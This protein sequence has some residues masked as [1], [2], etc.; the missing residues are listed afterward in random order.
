M[1]AFRWTVPTA[2]RAPVRFLD[3]DDVLCLRSPYGGFDAIAAV[4][5]LHFDAARVYLELFDP[6][7]TEAL[8]RV[9]DE[10]GAAMR[11]VISSTWR[12]SFSRVQLEIVFRHAGLAFV[13]DHLQEGEGWRTPPKFGRSRRIDEIAQWLERHH[14]SEPF[15][16]LDDTHSGASLGPALWPVDLPASSASP[17]VPMPALSGT[18]PPHPFAGRVVLCQENIGLTREHVPFIVEALRRAVSKPGMPR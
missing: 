14:K 17:N 5:G 2:V 4:T 9:H 18:E 13:A 15:A 11:Y 16:V 12:E 7:A 3:L 10:M 1:S 6:S 8:H